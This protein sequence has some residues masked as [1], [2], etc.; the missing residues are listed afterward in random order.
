MSV[1][2]KDL[3]KLK[4][5]II[6]VIREQSTILV[7]HISELQDSVNKFKRRFSVIEDRISDIE[8]D[9]IN[10][11]TTEKTIKNKVDAWELE[12]EKSKL[13]TI[14]NDKYPDWDNSIYR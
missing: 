7:G 11:E 10:L 12:K 6:G 1:S 13:H 4:S 2:Q 9:L 8:R 5:D 14:E 3:D